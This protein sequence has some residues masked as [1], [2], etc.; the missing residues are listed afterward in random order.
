MTLRACPL[1]DKPR[2]IDYGYEAEPTLHPQTAKE[3]FNTTP[4]VPK[5]NAIPAS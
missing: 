2:R 5:K 3:T 1:L 4:Q